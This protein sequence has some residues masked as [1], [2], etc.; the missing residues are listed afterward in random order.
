MEAYVKALEKN[1]T[2]DIRPVRFNYIGLPRSGKTTFRQRMME[3]YENIMKARASG[4]PDETSTGA[5]EDGGQILIKSEMGII[6]SKVWSA[7]KGDAGEASMLIQYLYQKVQERIEQMQPSLFPQQQS[8]KAPVSEIAKQVIHSESSNPSKQLLDVPPSNISSTDA[9]LAAA[10]VPQ[11]NTG[12]LEQYVPPS[13]EVVETCFLPILREALKTENSKAINFLLN[14]T[15]LLISTDT[16]GQAEFLDL[17]ASIVQSPSLNLLFSKLTEPFDSSYT[18]YFT[19]KEGKSTEKQQSSLTVE[20]VLFQTLASIACFNDHD[21]SLSDN[22]SD[23]EIY[24]LLK[25]SRSKVMF[26]GTFLDEVKDDAEYLVKRDAYLEEKIKS[27]TE[28]YKEIIA[29]ASDTNKQLTLQV[30]NMYGGK[31]EVKEIQSILER[32]I[33]EN[34]EKIPI[35]APW[36]L[37]NLFAR[38]TKKKVMTLKDCHHFVNEQNLEMSVKEVEN[39][40]WF[41]H[42]GIG[43]LL[44]Y[45]ELEELKDIVIFD[46]QVVFDSAT[47]LII[48]TYKTGK[49]NVQ[50]HEEFWHRGCFSVDDV[51]K[52]TETFTDDALLPLEKLIHLLKHLCILTPTPVS[53]GDDPEDSDLVEG[54]SATKSHVGSISS[55]VYFMPCVLKSAVVSELYISCVPNIAP[56]IF[57]F[58]CGF[59]PLGLFPSMITYLVANLSKGWKV[60]RNEEVFYKNR[61]PFTVFLADSGQKGWITLIMRPQYFEVAVTAIRDLTSPGLLCF[62]VRRDI[63]MALSELCKLRKYKVRHERAFECLVCPKS[64]EHLTANTD[65]VTESPKQ[66]LKHLCIVDPSDHP[67]YMECPKLAAKKETHHHGFHLQNCHKVWFDAAFKGML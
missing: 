41:L 38:Y 26:V 43:T 59:V 54:S 65:E 13:V 18:T 35:P 60:D 14:D 27:S 55:K 47:N 16:G 36:L 44:Y 24:R 49:V 57:H 32:I 67:Q 31:G 8:T 42:H 2:V 4:R 20:E 7:L 37:L 19:D 34:F 29:Y 21:K 10:T 28:I 11:I 52:A 46:K 66:F 45:P 61:I 1:F 17:Q 9:P 15:T 5:A 58:K 64:P 23:H 30:N 51:I 3:V 6:Q 33:D 40:L 63:E 12:S 39:A 22:E 48:T 25:K 53:L 56:L 50:K 62:K